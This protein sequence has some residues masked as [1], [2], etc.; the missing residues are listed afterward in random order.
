M[1]FSPPQDKLTALYRALPDDEKESYRLLAVALG[2]LTARLYVPMLRAASV[3]ASDFVPPRDPEGTL[4]SW[5]EA[6][7]CRLT[8]AP[9]GEAFS[10]PPAIREPVARETL[11]DG[12]FGLYCRAVETKIKLAPLKKRTFSEPGATSFAETW[13]AAYFLRKFLFLGD[14]E[15]L[16]ALGHVTV[17]G[18]RQPPLDE[19][20]ARE[21]LLNPSYDEEMVERLEEDVRLFFI[22]AAAGFTEDAALRRRLVTK[23]YDLSLSSG[24]GAYAAASAKALCDLGE[25]EKAVRLE[26][27]LT[28]EGQ[29][30]LRAVDALARGKRSE[31]ARLFFRLMS[32]APKADGSGVRAADPWDFFFLPLLASVGELPDVILQQSVL[33]QKRRSSVPGGSVFRLQAALARRGADAEREFRSSPLVK[34]LSRAVSSWTDRHSLASG[35]ETDAVAR[36]LEGCGGALDLVSLA[37]V[38]FLCSWIAPSLAKTW[39]PA[40]EPLALEL[41]RNGYVFLAG[42]LSAAARNVSGAAR[43]DEWHPVAELLAADSDWERALGALEKIANTGAPAGKR[44]LLWLVDWEP[45]ENPSS[46]VVF[47]TVEALEQRLSADGTWSKGRKVALSAIADGFERIPSLPERDRRLRDAVRVY[48]RG[49]RGLFRELD[50]AEAIRLLAGNPSVVRARGLVPLEIVTAEPELELTEGPD[51]CRVR[52]LTMP[53]AEGS[54]LVEEE[55]PTRLRVTTFSDTARGMA[56]ML[57]KGITVPARGRERL[58]KAISALSSRVSVR[59]NASEL[60]DAAPE[61]KCDCRLRAR[62]CPVG[63]GLNVEFVTRPFGADGISCRPGLGAETLYGNVK[64]ASGLGLR[65]RVRRD[66]A[67]EKKTFDAAVAALPVLERAER[68]S[69]AA[70]TL[71]CPE[72]CLEFL[73]QLK[74]VPDIA[75][76]WPRGGIRSVRAELDGS[77]LTGAAQS[78]GT[79]WFAVSGTAP[80]DESLTLSLAQLIALTRESRGRFVPIGDGQYL[81]LTREFERRIRLLGSL[82]DEKGGSLLLPP[83]AAPAVDELFGQG[84]FAADANWTGL[85]A[86]FKEAAR[87]R[88]DVPRTLRAELRPYQAEGFRWLARLAH[89]GAGACLADEMGLGKTV[90]ALALL[91][92]RAH[93]GPALVV[94]PTSVCGNWRDE[95]ERFA[96]ALNVVDYRASRRESVLNSL[97][98]FDVAL[99]SYG[100]LQNNADAFARVSWHTIVLDEAQAVKNMAT[101]RSAAVMNLKGGFRMVMT[102]TPVEN[103]LNELWNLFRFLNSGLLGSL[104]RFNRV[105]AAPIADGDVNARARLRRVV[106]PF[107]LRRTKEQVLDDLPPRTDVTVKFDLSDAERAFYEALRASAAEAIDGAASLPDRDKRLVIFSQIMKLRRCCCSVSLT[108]EGA[109][110]AAD[111]PSSKTENLLALAAQLHDDGHRA[112]IFSQ[113]TDHLRIVK[114]ALENAGFACL[115]LDGSTPAAKRTELVSRFQSGE[116]DFFLLSLR[117]GGTGLNLTAADYVLHLDPW[118]NPAVED[119]ASDRAH[120]IGQTRPVIVYRLV[121]RDTIEEKILALH[122]DKRALAADILSG[123]SPAAI[124]LDFLAGLIRD[125]E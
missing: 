33:Q 117:A 113:F 95:A 24:D 46:R 15:G 86:R 43:K 87:M 29:T 72:D 112:L 110:L 3:E 81:A 61:V 40:F 58:L 54:V 9:D 108:R 106:S 47:P 20:F 41:T 36:L 48:R 28:K 124:D 74:K 103:N 92:S 45:P 100:L 18:R 77:T 122:R 55:T 50:S 116:G 8:S 76:E 23:M 63:E 57:G 44:R 25:F 123:G 27:F 120:R 102:G 35:S 17:T 6:G 14:S 59:S 99:V 66:L 51:T 30:R 119:Q 85:C 13:R 60:R 105:F 65:A 71:R 101:R 21:V 80:V 11:A 111:I 107:L 115:S 83:I 125:R 38:F 98:P 56:S 53:P 90:Q 22:K 67:R 2:P 32:P 75:V 93:D 91:L 78:S 7:L 79:D 70:W 104:D 88:P 69:E 16:R 31:A 5:L 73:L 49:F 94:A 39:L 10:V 84:V 121:A 96:P 37:H 118:W 82:A 97:S 34:S 62:I 109:R 12:T 4:K 42:E 19:F 64:D 114:T 89:C 68:Q 1:F 26:P 52:L